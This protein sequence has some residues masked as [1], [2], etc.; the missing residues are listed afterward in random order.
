ML[1][2]RS[3]TLQIPDLLRSIPDDKLLAMHKRV[4]FVYETFLRSLGTQ[5]LTGLMLG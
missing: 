4:V 2:L 3:Y 5:V 1:I